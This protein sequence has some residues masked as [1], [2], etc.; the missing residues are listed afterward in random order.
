MGDGLQIK[1]CAIH[2]CLCTFT[3]L[4]FFLKLTLENFL[5]TAELILDEVSR[6]EK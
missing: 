2:L 3:S 1:K 4:E 5:E 6:G